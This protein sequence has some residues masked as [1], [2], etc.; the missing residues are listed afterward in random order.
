[1]DN[2]RKHNDFIE[3]LV[4]LLSPSRQVL[5]YYLYYTTPAPNQTLQ[6]IIHQSF[7][8]PMLCNPIT[9]ERKEHS[10]STN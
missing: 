7:S 6:Y 5:G 8:R 9:N 1:M 2:V 4:V 3:I 10:T